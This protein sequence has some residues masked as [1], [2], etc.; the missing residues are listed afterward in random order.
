M[1]AGFIAVAARKDLRRIRRDPFSLAVWLG[2]PVV[3]AAMLSLLF[4]REPVAPQG[5]LLVADED[6]TFLSQA[7]SAA[8]TRGPL[9]KMILVEKTT[10]EEGR[11]RI[12]RGDA[13]AFLVIPKGLQ[14]AFLENRP[15][16]LTL[17]T[18]P[19]QRIL[20]QI[21]EETLSIA[22]DAG[23][24]L[25]QVAGDQLRV[26][27]GKAA[28]ADE[29]IATSA[30]AFNRIG[31]SVRR[32][33]DPPLIELDTA[34]VAE[35][36]PKQSKS[37]VALLFPTTL[38]M[39]LLFI[40]NG[41]AFDIWR[42]RMAGTL[43]RLAMS[44]VSMRAFLAGRLVTVAMVVAAVGAL[45][46]GALM[47][48]A[49]LPA[50]R[51]P[52]AAL[53]IVLAGCVFFLLLLLLALQPSTP[54]AASVW[55]NLVILPLMMVGGGFMPFEM[56]PDWMARVGRLTPNGWALARFT[57]IL[58]GAAGPLDVALACAGL[59]ALGAAAFLLAARSLR[60]AQ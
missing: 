16:R 29:T 25:R 15:A 52:G 20:P 55:G 10:A 49:G 2:I 7:F 48:L 57:A 3:L 26:F 30:V 58:D 17:L 4:G 24:Y 18:N 53:W 14:Q 31:Q 50:A 54:R 33:L 47:A 46:L 41:L 34:V 32:Y 23:F 45:G 51:V 13:S 56:M 36:R 42:E 12:G 38:F 37:F 19:S 11:A 59:T 43:R 28:P 27:T 22:T 8:F 60:R 9:G 40:A 6:A 35:S 39:S 5:R 21:V 1:S 44:P